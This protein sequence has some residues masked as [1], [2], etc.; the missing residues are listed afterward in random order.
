MTNMTIELTQ[1]EAN[2]LLRALEELEHRG[3]DDAK[4]KKLWD[5][6]FTTGL[7]AGFGIPKDFEK[8]TNNDTQY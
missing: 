4:T 6:I 7:D 1:A 8:E 3:D 2:T 5:K